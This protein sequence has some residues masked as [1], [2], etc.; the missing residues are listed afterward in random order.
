MSRI[1][2]CP[3]VLFLGVALFLWGALAP[4][5][6]AGRIE[7]Q[8]ARITK[9]AVYPDR[10]EVLRQAQVQVPIGSSEVAFLDVPYGVEPDS[11]RVS[12]HGVSA[13]LGAVELKDEAQTPAKS[14]EFIAADKDV[15]RLEAELAALDAQDG[16]GND[17]LDYLRSLKNIPTAR[18][19]AEKPGEAPKIDPA[20]IQ[21]IY[22]ILKTDLDDLSRQTLAR[23]TKRTELQEAVQVARAKRDAAKPQGSIRSRT[24][25]IEVQARQAGA[26]TL[27]LSYV[28]P[29]A[30]WRP[31][32]RATLDA[33]S[34]EVD[35]VAEGVVVQ[36]SGEDWDN[37]ALTLSTA[38]PAR[39]VEPPELTAWLL[40]PYEPDAAFGRAKASQVVL[41]DEAR[42]APGVAGAMPAPPP[43]PPPDEIAEIE[44]ADIVH[45]AYNVSFDVPGKTTVPA[46]GR[47]HR[48]TLDRETLKSQVTYRTAP[49]AV[50]AAFLIA[51]AHAPG[52]Y[53]LLSGPMRVFAGP[54]YLGVWNIKETGPGAELTVPFGQDNRVVVKHVV[55][56]QNQSREGFISKDKVTTFGF[57]TTVENLRDV[58]VDL[59]L[60]DRIPVSQ[61]ERIKV[62]IGDATT[63]GHK[64]VPDRPGILEWTLTLNPKEKK[65]VVLEYSVRRPRDLNVP[66]L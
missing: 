22:G 14:E 8:G 44:T 2:R 34:G 65:E 23:K 47:E 37:V 35:L 56:P 42:M 6:R 49:A 50:E 66:G 39:G 29:G 43:P 57:K 40:R 24:A 63:K 3:S 46:D 17:L 1:G 20:A 41:Q 55:L 12:A 59:V 16:V 28:A 61:D 51:K 52:G 27:E 53:P 32:Y 15:K 48:V 21:A 11:V 30:F 13:V 36:R 45:T 25:V 54:T 60:E 64:D 62:E 18:L 4:A 5:A 31:A 33:T 7:A 19:P 9:V 26:L 10:A 38:A 58:K